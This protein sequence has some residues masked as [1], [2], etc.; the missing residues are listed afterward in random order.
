MSVEYPMKVKTFG[1]VFSPS[2]IAADEVIQGL[3]ENCAMRDDLLVVT[4][5]GGIRLFIQANGARWMAPE[6]FWKWVGE[7]ETLVRRYL[8]KYS[9]R[10]PR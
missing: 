9:G 1:Y 8:D 4:S 7:N 10:L 3:V 5:D 2:G 6:E